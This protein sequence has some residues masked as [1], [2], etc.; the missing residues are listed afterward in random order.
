[1]TGTRV[2][3]ATATFRRSVGWAV[4]AGCGIVAA[5]IVLSVLYFPASKGQMVGWTA[6]AQGYALVGMALAALFVIRHRSWGAAPL[7][8]WLAR[9]PHFLPVLL[10]VALGLRL[11]GIA[12]LQWEPYGDYSL[13]E[14]R[15]WSVS[16]GQ[17][18]V[19]PGKGPDAHWPPGFVLFASPF[20]WLFG[21]S[22]LLLK[23]LNA[24]IDAVSAVLVW[25]LAL[26]IWRNAGWARLAGLLYA[27]NPALV[28][29]SQVIVYAPLL[30]FL[31]LLISLTV[32][33][34]FVWCGLL[35]GAGSLVKPVLLPGPA[36]IVLA[37]YIG[38]SS[39]ARACVRGLAAAIVM[40]VVI[41]PWT[42][43]NFVNF[44]RFVL[45]SANAGYLM[46]WGNHDKATGLLESWSPEQRSVAGKDLI[47]LD[48]RLNREAWRWIVN[49][50][51]AFLSLV[52]IKLA[53]NFGTEL[54]TLPDN[55][56]YPA[57]VPELAFRIVV[58][59]FYLVLALGFGLALWR[60]RRTISTSAEATAALCFVF[61]FVAIHAIFVGWSF[62][63]QP[64]LGIMSALW[65]AL[66]SA[67]REQGGANSR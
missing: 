29:V 61:G 8:D 36:V 67:P 62:Y 19:T 20:Y 60:G 3:Q 26:E 64:V 43:R 47:D 14:L 7:A 23:G 66:L 52:P 17:G 25:R 22:V 5:A 33:R 39:F 12:V 59:T 34:S 38:G 2:D 56:N 63:H 35:L 55:L 65:P 48:R 21:R 45:V 40:L 58:Q 44:D 28:A 18:Y 42:V 10:L 6:A 50:P 37:S 27:V 32:R 13:H 24:C 53:H 46:S 54:A 41:S 16:Q 51:G 49:N 15:I 31:L 4:R 57:Y 30:C 1:M 11:L 9:Q